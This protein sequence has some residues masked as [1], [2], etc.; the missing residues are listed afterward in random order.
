MTPT[1]IGSSLRQPYLLGIY[2]TGE[3]FNQ[4]GAWLDT[5]RH[6]GFYGKFRPFTANLNVNGIAFWSTTTANSTGS[7]A[8]LHN[9]FFTA[10][11]S[12]SDSLGTYSRVGPATCT[13][14][15][16]NTTGA[17]SGFLWR[18]Y[19]ATDVDLSGSFRFIGVPSNTGASLPAFA[20]ALAARVT[21]AAQNQGTNSSHI[22]TCNGYL[23]GVFGNNT[24]SQRLFYLLVKLSSGTPA[25]LARSSITNL[26]ALFPSNSNTNKELRFT[27][28]TVGADVE[29]VGYIKNASG[30]WSQVIS[31]TDTG[32]AATIPNGRCGLV[33]SGENS[34]IAAIGQ[35]YNATQ[36]NWWELKPYG[37]S[38]VLREHWERVNTR[39]GRIC[40]LPSGFNFPHSLLGHSLLHGWVGDQSSYD[41]TGTQS[42]EGSFRVDSANERVQLLPATTSTRVLNLWQRI[43]PASTQQDMQ[44]S[45]TIGP[46]AGN[47]TQVRVGLVVFATPNLTPAPSGNGYQTALSAQARGYLLE[48]WASDVGGVVTWSLA[49]QRMRFNASNTLATVLT[50]KVV[51]TLA[52]NVPFVLRVSALSLVV[53]TAGNGYIRLRAYLNGTQVVWDTA[54]GAYPGFEV[55][56]DGTV[57]DN[58][59]QRIN[60][61]LAMGVSC[62]A[63][64][65]SWLMYVDSFQPAT[66][67]T[68]VAEQ[69]QA[70]IAV[71]A[72]DDTVSGTFSLPYDWGYQ[73]ASAWKQ[74]AHQFD[75]DYRYAQPQQQ[76]ARRR[77]NIGCDSATAAEVA[78]L[79]SFWNTQKGAEV[80]FF[81]TT[82]EGETVAARFA[83]DSL[84]IER[85]T[86]A[87]HRWSAVLE[88]VIP[89]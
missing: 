21:G 86:S 53:P 89:E 50:S 9:R 15:A 17:V 49:L 16:T 1:P 27:C 36:C 71:P 61:G 4:Q 25:E 83:M 55:R 57:I 64:N 62:Y 47:G 48:V 12:V 10:S 8:D 43:A 56:A 58:G 81:W 45:F 54:V 38:I 65:L 39:G 85:V 60:G 5:T 37:G 52:A 42:Y 51:S 13:N 87:V 67:P 82:V 44:A 29:L 59:T 22:T 34:S 30:A 76:V 6:F 28:R 78:T 24:G 33:L 75:A 41:E 72:E 19:L 7:S 11:P 14:L 74:T 69:D 2:P 68:D 73:V 66:S 63:T 80:P 40:S 84:D 46:S 88:E 3:N 26:A 20:Y 31:Y 77:W 70:T 18:D 79:R 35:S 23:F 32:A